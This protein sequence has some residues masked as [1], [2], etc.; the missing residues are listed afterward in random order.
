MLLGR[1]HPHCHAWSSAR[2]LICRQRVLDRI[3]G[4]L[5]ACGKGVS[6]RILVTGE[7]ICLLPCT[8]VAVAHDHG[9]HPCSTHIQGTALVA[10]C[11]FLLR[12]TLLLNSICRRARY[13]GS[14]RCHDNSGIAQQQQHPSS[15]SYNARCG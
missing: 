9:A 13:P 12:T 15:M 6:P 10:P 2:L 14:G 4:L 8:C 11:P 1:L 7:R 5:E 3:R